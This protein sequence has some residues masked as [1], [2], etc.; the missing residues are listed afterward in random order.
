MFLLK[1]TQIQLFIAS[2]ENQLVEVIAQSIRAANGER[3]AGYDDK[4]LGS[5]VK[6]GIE[7]ARSHELTRAEDIAAYVAVMF[8]VAPRFDEQPE[9]REVFHDAL[10]SPEARFYQIFDR[11]KEDAWIEAQ[12]KYEDSFWFTAGTASN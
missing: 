8:E 11:V 2:D 1:T 10:F 12:K 9:F 4:D 5:M 3:V 6:I 7:R